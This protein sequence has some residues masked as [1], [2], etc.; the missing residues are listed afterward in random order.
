MLPVAKAD[1]DTGEDAA[2]DA[3]LRGIGGRVRR[4]RTDAGLSIEALATLAHMHPTHVSS[5]E[6]GVRN[7][8]IFA[9]AKLADGLGIDLGSLVDLTGEL[10]KGELRKSVNRKLRGADAATL[11]RAAKLLDVLST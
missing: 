4:L 6:R 7:A 8:S 2:R 10:S 9:Y 3:L 11:R 5:I 1:Q